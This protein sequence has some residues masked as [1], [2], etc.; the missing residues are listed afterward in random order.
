M[1]VDIGVQLSAGVS[2]DLM[3][4]WGSKG[5]VRSAKEAPQPSDRGLSKTPWLR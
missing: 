5:A 3:A 4:V 2:K 1:S